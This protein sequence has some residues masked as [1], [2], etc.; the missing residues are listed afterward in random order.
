MGL[1]GRI[2]LKWIFKKWYAG[3]DLIGLAQDRNK[4]PAVLK[5]VMNLWI[6]QNVES[7]VSSCRATSFLSR[8][9]LHAV[10]S[11]YHYKLNCVWR[12]L[13]C[14]VRNIAPTTLQ[15]KLV[16][17]IQC[18]SLQFFLTNKTVAIKRPILLLLLSVNWNWWML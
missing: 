18:E 17:S 5:A 4:W 15:K 2:I 1:D 10:N 9:Q 16:Q 12:R 7:L 11:W 13:R 14:T 6:A 3:M 8:T